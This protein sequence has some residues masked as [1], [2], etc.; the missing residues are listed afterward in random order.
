LVDAYRPRAYGRADVN[1]LLLLSALLSALTGVTGGA[2]IAP[3]P[4][5]VSQGM[6]AI[7]PAGGRVRAIATRPAAAL[8][9]LVALAAVSRFATTVMAPAE[10]ARLLTNR[11]R[12]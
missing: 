10:A 1:L 4:Q 3:A 2:R 6:A 8:P 12:E 5:S 9:T 7:A 11:R